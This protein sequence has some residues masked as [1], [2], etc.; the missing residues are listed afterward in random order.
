MSSSVRFPEFKDIKNGKAFLYNRVSTDEQTK[1]LL[2]QHR[3]TYN[4]AT[5]NGLKVGCTLS[6]TGTA[7]KGPRKRL[8]D[9]IKFLTKG[10]VIIVTEAS[11]ISRKS[12]KGLKFLT[13]CALKGIKVMFLKEK[14]VYTANTAIQ[15]EQVFKYF[16]AAEAETKMMSDRQKRRQAQL[17]RDGFHTGGKTSYGTRLEQKENELHKRVVEDPFEKAR[18]DFIKFCRR[19]GHLTSAAITRNLSHIYEGTG[20]DDIKNHPVKIVANK[21]ESKEPFL[22]GPMSNRTIRLLLNDYEIRRIETEPFKEWTTTQIRLIKRDE[23]GLATAMEVMAIDSKESETQPG[24]ETDEDENDWEMP[25]N[26]SSSSSSSSSEEELL[27]KLLSAVELANPNERQIHV[28][29]L[30]SYLIATSK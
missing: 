19:S 3:D 14:F 30:T 4:A 29:R 9:Q 26:Q 24:Y 18:I 25:N 1:S 22:I 5:V 8:K 13:A 16:K 23:D 2:D 27:K 12:I 7:T 20:D 21:R 15:N 11:R 10:T 6:E 17:K 28:N